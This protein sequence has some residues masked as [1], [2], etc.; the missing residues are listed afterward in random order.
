MRLIPLS[1]LNPREKEFIR[2]WSSIR[3]KGKL[4]YM[5]TRTLL[6]GLLLFSVWLTVTA[7]EISN[8]EFQKAIFTWRDFGFRCL[9]WFC[10]Y[11]LLGFVIARGLWKRNEERYH[12][13][14]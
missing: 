1:P 13:L 6:L 14:S 4:G 11:Q 9:N 2:R 10:F 12:Y 8:S 3:Q 5:L 7:I